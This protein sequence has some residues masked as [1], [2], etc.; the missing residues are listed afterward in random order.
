MNS[1][2]VSTVLNVI[3]MSVSL[4][5]F[6]VLFAQVWFDCRFNSNFED[7][8]NIYRLEIPVMSD[9]SE[10]SYR[11]DMGRATVEAMKICSPDIVAACD[12]DDLN[13]YSDE[14][15]CYNDNGTVTKYDMPYAETDSSFPDVFKL[16]IVAG[17]I[18]NYNRKNTALLS[19]NY[20][21]TIFGDRNPIGEVL[22]HDMYGD[23]YEIVAVYKTL[24]EN[25]TV[26]NGM[27]INEGDDDISFVNR[28]FH[29]GFYK[30]K[31]GASVEGVLET[32]RDAYRKTVEGNSMYDAYREEYE[33]AF[34]PNFRLTSLAD[35]HFLDDCKSSR[36]PYADRIQTLI[37]LSISM[38][39]LLISILNYVNFAIAAIPFRINDVNISKVFGA[40]KEQ[41]MFTQLK[42]N[43]IVCLA[44]F[45]LAL[46]LMEMVSDSQFASFSSCSLSVKDNISAILVSLVIAVFSAVAG[47][48]AA[49]FYTTSFA[50]GMVLKG[51]FA[52]SGK[53]RI[54][55]KVSMISQY[56]LSC[57]FL[58]CGLMIGRQ[59]DYMMQADNGYVTEGILHMNS[60]LWGRWY[61]DFDELMKNPDVIAVTCGDIPMDEG[62]SSRNTLISKDGEEA[63]YSY[64]SA[65]WSY[66]DFFGFELIEGRFPH[67]DEEN[68]AV[69]NEKFASTFPDYTIGSKLNMYQRY[70][71]EIVGVVKDFNAR[72]M[73]Y[74]TDPVLYTVHKFNFADLYF[75]L[76]TDEI[77]E[78]VDWINSTMKSTLDPNYNDK[79]TF[80]TSFLDDDI[81]NLYRKE[82]GQARLITNS[83][84]LCLLIALIGVLGIVYFETQVMRREIA[85]RKVNGATTGEIMRS[86]IRKY[87]TVSTIGFAIA[88]PIS[89]FIIDW[90]LSGFANRTDISIEIFILSYLIIT[91][92]TAAVVFIRSY[93]AASANPAEALKKE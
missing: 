36:K 80:E 2:R 58:I 51:D 63:W 23:T 76:R 5:V 55:R 72:P 32:M 43:I 66:F 73:M 40:S 78:T 7:Y 47:G 27:L 62:V 20:A 46:C 53:G 82:I 38:L 39:F 26:N 41:L 81:E 4:M 33:R 60:D 69:I 87:I 42:Y 88:V 28:K 48:L 29:V 15:I 37:L 84:L 71:Y 9:V 25:C 77:S 67:R 93:A 92:L 30:I 86:L 74:E 65:Y 21:R 10:Y 13:I 17:S 6:L 56:V 83:S 85:I 59:N 35:V 22:T 31:D 24:P 50:P 45:A 70:E 44:A 49:A 14:K 12:Y 89:V 3:G 34:Y 90:W 54:F 52:I 61:E 91:I 18:D 79:I 16:D 8:K 57:V 1:K 11:H 75:K 64:R 68:V 19:E